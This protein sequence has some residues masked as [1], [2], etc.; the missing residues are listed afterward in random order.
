MPSQPPRTRR[1]SLV[2]G[3]GLMSLL[4]GCELVRAPEE[5]P[6]TR[7]RSLNQPRWEVQPGDTDA[8]GVV[9]DVG[10]RP[11]PITPA[12]EAAPQYRGVTQTLLETFLRTE[13]RDARARALEQASQ[14]FA[15]ADIREAYAAI[16]SGRQQDASVG[17]ALL[18]R[19]YDREANKS[20]P[21]EPEGQQTRRSH[22]EKLADAYR[23]LFQ[24]V[25]AMRLSP[26]HLA[27]NAIC[28]A[29][30][31][32]F[33]A[34]LAEARTADELFRALPVG[35]DTRP[36]LARL[37]QAQAW[38][39]EGLARAALKSGVPDAESRSLEQLAVLYWQKYLT[40]ARAMG[41]TDAIQALELRQAEQHLQNLRQNQAI[42]AERGLG[43]T[44]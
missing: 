11:P 4:G 23:L 16:Q 3:C 24:S 26:E 13:L 31:G 17:I 30:L 29:M 2:W 25:P 33:Q 28:L 19:Y 21:T 36:Q 35:D 15:E 32:Q 39:Y 12:P 44:P 43:D 7:L 20:N 9:T 10:V 42:A 41:S 5:A 40:T 14:A 8:S 1:T 38:S 34:S 27:E 6:P 22:W 18:S 37:A